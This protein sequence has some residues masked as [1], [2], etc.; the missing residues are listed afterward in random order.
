MKKYKADYKEFS[1]AAEAKGGWKQR[2]LL[3]PPAVSWWTVTVIIW[4]MTVTVTVFIIV[5]VIY[6]FV[7][8]VF[9]PTL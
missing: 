4:L 8:V 6:H 3:D 9:S 5:I 2:T 7:S 1:A